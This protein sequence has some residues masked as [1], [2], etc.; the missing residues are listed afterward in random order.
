MPPVRMNK[1][2]QQTPPAAVVAPVVPTPVVTPAAEAGASA[3]PDVPALGT[4]ENEGGLAP[5][6]ADAPADPPKREAPAGPPAI[7]V[8]R[9]RVAIEVPML[10][11]D[12]APPRGRALRIDLALNVEESR[13]FFLL[14][15]ALNEENV[16]TGYAVTNKQ[17]PIKW[18]LRRLAEAFDAA[19]PAAAAK[20]EA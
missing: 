19:P 1:P 13:G 4:W 15:Q 18:L 20:A 10:R 3:P 17:E 11:F 6:K 12:E 7:R 5:A 9:K 8:T 14:Q 2:H 16:F